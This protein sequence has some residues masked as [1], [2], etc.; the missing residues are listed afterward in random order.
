MVQS[1]T[2]LDFYYLVEA[3]L[4]YLRSDGTKHLEVWNYSENGYPQKKDY[5]ASYEIFWN[6]YTRGEPEKLQIKICGTDP[7][8]FITLTVTG[9]GP[10]KLAQIEKCILERD[11]RNG[12]VMIYDE[13]SVI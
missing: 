10:E 5:P 3:N 11:P 13:E 4:Y 6:N 12:I 1:D 8:E 7:V 2:K 9:T